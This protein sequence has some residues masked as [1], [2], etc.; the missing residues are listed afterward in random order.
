MGEGGGGTGLE[1][2]GRK[3]PVGEDQGG[4]LGVDQAPISLNHS[5]FS[6]LE[7]VLSGRDFTF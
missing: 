3:I 6:N 2:T 5:S 4:G 7:I 1:K